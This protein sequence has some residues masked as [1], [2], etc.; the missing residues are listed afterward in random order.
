MQDGNCTTVNQLR[1]THRVAA[2][3]GS[4]ACLDIPEAAQRSTGQS[5]RLKPMPMP[6]TA[7]CIPLFASIPGVASVSVVIL[8]GEQRAC[9]WKLFAQRPNWP[10]VTEASDRPVRSSCASTACPKLGPGA[11]GMPNNGSSGK[12]MPTNRKVSPGSPQAGGRA[13]RRQKKRSGE[14]TDAHVCACEC[15]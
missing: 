4:S 2:W 8:P 9:D 14:W 13:H 1:I 12:G 3:G 11:R 15:C 6:L 10:T 5:S 7:C